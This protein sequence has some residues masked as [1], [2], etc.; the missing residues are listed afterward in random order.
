[1]YV[2]VP[3]TASSGVHWLLLPSC[4]HISY[5]RIETQDQL[6][7]SALNRFQEVLVLA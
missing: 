1:M 4:G 3:I 6:C 5:N 2:N 7:P